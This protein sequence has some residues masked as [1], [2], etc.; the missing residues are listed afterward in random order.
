MKGLIKLLVLGSIGAALFFVRTG[1]KLQGLK[2][3]LSS[4]AKVKLSGAALQVSL[5]LKIYNPN[6]KEGITL[7]EINLKISDR[8]GNDAKIVKKGINQTIPPKAIKPFNVNVKIDLLGLANNLL[9]SFLSSGRVYNI[10]KELDVTGFI[11]ADN[12]NY[13]VTKTVK[14]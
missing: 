14:T 7:Q 8:R 6:E 11:K 5:G 1:K 10:P 13:P 4:L 9:D 2:I 12:M 3:D